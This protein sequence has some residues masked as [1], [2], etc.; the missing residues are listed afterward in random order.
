MVE[1]HKQVDWYIYCVEDNQDRIKQLFFTKILSQKIPKYNHKVLLL[2]TTYK[3]NKYKMF[4]I[5]I[6]GVIPLNTSYYIAFVFISKK[7]FEIHKWLLECFKDLY[8]YLD[9][10]DPDVILTDTQNSLI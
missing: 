2:D 3:T 9:I 10:P 7:T 1:L 4:L 5:I 6:S 8:E